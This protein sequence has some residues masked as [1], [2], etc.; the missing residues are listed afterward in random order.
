MV[1][2]SRD[3]VTREIRVVLSDE[4]FT[5]EENFTTAYDRDAVFTLD[6]AVWDTDNPPTGVFVRFSQH[7]TSDNIG[8]L[9][10][11]DGTGGIDEVFETGFAVLGRETDPN[12]IPTGMGSLS[13]EGK[14]RMLGFPS[15]NGATESEFF[16]QLSGDMTLVMGLADQSLS[17]DFTGRYS[18]CGGACR[19]DIAGEL[20]PT[21]IAGNGFNTT[22][23]F[24]GCG[25]AT[26][27]GTGDIGGV[28]YDQDAETLAGVMAIDLTLA[29]LEAVPSGSETHQIQT[30]GYFSTGTNE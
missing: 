26:C 29:G 18:W 16:A 22:F 9:L 4:S 30:V 6:G 7:I 17:G 1:R 21:Q 24:T 8:E 20:A 11:S 15:V 5:L 14:F 3:P 28:F 19:Y 27:S 25:T 10:I 23:I 12:D 13:Y 2:I